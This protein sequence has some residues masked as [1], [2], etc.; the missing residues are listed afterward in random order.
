ML[1]ITFMWLI[2]FITGSLY[3]LIS[4]TYFSHPPHPPPLWQPPVSSLYL[5]VYS[6]LLHLF[7]SCVFQIPHISEIIWYFSF[8]VWLISF[9]II[10]TRSIHVVANGKILFFFLWLI[11]CCINIA[12]LPY[13]FIYQWALRLFL[14]LGDCK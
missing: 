7:I 1:Y 11:I 4:L 12:H 6:V 2:Y 8:S 5:W 13:P 3:L 10:P 14:Y 9:S